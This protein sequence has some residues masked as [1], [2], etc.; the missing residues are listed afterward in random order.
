VVAS[1]G[2][3][4]EELGA[5]RPNAQGQPHMGHPAHKTA[6]AFGLFGLVPPPFLM[7]LQD[8]LKERPCSKPEGVAF[9]YSKNP[10]M[11]HKPEAEMD[12]M[13]LVRAEPHLPVNC[14]I[15]NIFLTCPLF[16]EFEKSIDLKGI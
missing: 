10:V 9:L 5:R 15:P 4:V 7:D 16:I 2:L 3:R 8:N 6:N 12:L 1:Y 11:I 14:I 13:G